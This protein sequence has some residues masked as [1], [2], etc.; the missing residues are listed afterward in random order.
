M[1]KR[2][3]DRRVA[4]EKAVQEEDEQLKLDEAAAAE[5]LVLREEHQ[6][7]KTKCMEE[8]LSCQ[9]DVYEDVAASTLHKNS[10]ILLLPS[11]LV[12]EVL[13]TPSTIPESVTGVE[14]VAVMTALQTERQKTL[15]AYREAQ[16]YRNLSERIRK[17][18]RVLANSLHE[19]IELVRDFWRNN[20][21]EG[22]TRAGRMVQ[23]ALQKRV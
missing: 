2:W 11:V 14:R 20:I 13:D 3:K 23:K 7:I 1:R 17:E 22:S 8:I 18:K 6:C 15:K 5:K 12:P 10:D 19:K 4:Y 9:E 21:K 16:Y